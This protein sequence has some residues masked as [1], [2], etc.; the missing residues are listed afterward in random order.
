MHGRLRLDKLAT[1]IEQFLKQSSR[2]EEDKKVAVLDS[3]ATSVRSDD[4][5]NRTEFSGTVYY[6][7]NPG[8]K[9]VPSPKAIQQEIDAAVPLTQVLASGN[10]TGKLLSVG[11]SF[12]PLCRHQSLPPRLPS[13]FSAPSIEGGKPSYSDMIHPET[14]V[15]EKCEIGEPKEKTSPGTSTMR[16][17]RPLVNRQGNSDLDNIDGYDSETDDDKSVDYVAVD[18]PGSCGEDRKNI[19]LIPFDQLMLIE[20]LGTG[21][22]STIYRAVWKRS[23]MGHPPAAPDTPTGAQMLALKVAMVNTVTLDTSHVDEMRQEADIAARLQHPHICD[24]VGVAVDSE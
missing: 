16:Q 6:R 1:Y 23:S 10:G 4:S 24:L 3:G 18:I 9:E 15:P 12:Q 20:T 2:T 7:P 21:R 13:A 17:R 5:R 11:S 19:P 22:V 14:E 8:T